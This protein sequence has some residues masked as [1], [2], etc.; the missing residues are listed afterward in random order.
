VLAWR[1]PDLP[2]RAQPGGLAAQ[3]AGVRA[4][5]RNPRFWW[6]AP[7]GGLGM[8]S[9]MAIQ[10]LWA[11]PW[12]MQVDGLTRAEAARYLLT[13]GVVILAGYAFIA[14]FA[15]RLAQQ[16]VESRHLFGIGFAL[17][18]VALCAIALRLPGSFLWWPLY[19]LGAAANILAFTVLNEGFGRDV[20]ARAN[21]AL[22]L[23]M[24]GGSFV[25]QWGI[26]VV[27]EAAAAS[28][29]LD[30]A[31]GLRAAFAL[32]LVADVLGFA[33]FARGWHRHAAVEAVPA[34]A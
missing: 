29:G 24:I 32:V 4:V 10:G 26:G 31:G 34:R 22:N 19:A 15:R 20:A 30:A 8:G 1:V 18:A 27:A 17:N 6:I 9:F 2:P 11:V 14:L 7:L 13:M 5:Y 25:V 3:W 16:G 28:A 23:M 21:T 33:W 12:L